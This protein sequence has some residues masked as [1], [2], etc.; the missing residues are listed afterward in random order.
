MKKIILL[1]LLTLT[2]SASDRIFIMTESFHTGSEDYNN[3]NYGIGYE[4]TLHSGLGVQIGTYRNSYDNQTVLAGAHY[5][6]KL[7]DDLILNASLSYVT[8]YDN[9]NF[10]PLVGVQ[11]EYVRVVT[12]GY[13]TNLQLVF[14][15]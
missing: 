10:I 7:I 11:Y 15:F 6:Y 12:N 13:V 9:I 3:H 4:H 14:E 8:N 1:I 2:I 5:R